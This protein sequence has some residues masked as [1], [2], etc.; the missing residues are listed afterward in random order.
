MIFGHKERKERKGEWGFLP[1]RLL[2]PLGLD[3][4]FDQETEM[5]A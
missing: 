4:D 3:K 1:L 5:N 2:R